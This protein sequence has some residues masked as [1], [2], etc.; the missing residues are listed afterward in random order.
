MEKIIK[1]GKAGLVG[2]SVSAYEH[3][4]APMVGW[5]MG[6]YDHN[7]SSGGLELVFESLTLGAI[8]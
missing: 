6:K 5:C 2:Y 3:I 8:G 1:L 4:L 7:N